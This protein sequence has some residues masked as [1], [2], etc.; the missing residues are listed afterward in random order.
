MYFERIKYNEWKRTLVA[1]LIAVVA[2]EVLVNAQFMLG[3]P[4]FVIGGVVL[5]FFFVICLVRLEWGLIALLLLSLSASRVPLY[6]QGPASLFL[7]E[8]LLTVIFIAYLLHMLVRKRGL[9][10]DAPTVPLILLLIVAG[11]S[12]VHGNLFWDESVPT[13]HR[14]LIVQVAGVVLIALPVATF[15]LFAN[16]FDVRKNLNWLLPLFIIMPV[17]GAMAVLGTVPTV[18]A[19]V[20]FSSR[21]GLRSFI[22]ASPFWASPLTGWNTLRGI[23]AA[24]IFSASL[25]VPDKTKRLILW[26]LLVPLLIVDVLSLKVGSWIALVCILLVVAWFHSKKLFGVFLVVLVAMM[27]M[28]SIV[29]EGN[30][31]DAVLTN[32]EEKGSFDRLL[33]WQDGLTI[34]STSPV[35]GVGP[36]NYYSYSYRYTSF[37]QVIAGSS[38]LAGKEQNPYG[39]AHNGYIQILAEVGIAGFALFMWFIV[40]T[41]RAGIKTYNRAT[42]NREKAFVLGLLGGI[43][44]GLVQMFTMNGLYHSINNGGFMTFVAGM[45]TWAAAGMLVQLSRSRKD[46]PAIDT[47]TAGT[48]GI[49]RRSTGKIPPSHRE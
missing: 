8:V 46:L 42:S 17:I 15:L 22:E 11:L 33:I 6:S 28:E 49:G 25:I 32:A 43:A 44:G 18:I 12:L 7:A 1:A 16:C 2:V 24:V 37:P 23:G 10:L 41:L 48:S 20:G 9:S 21:G 30:T 27:A 47:A 36:G 19:S 34:W 13:D 31:V 39:N 38:R 26:G 40:A 4:D 45:Y 35:V 5:A 29:T 14:Y 3:R